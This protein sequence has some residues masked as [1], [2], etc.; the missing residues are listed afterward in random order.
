MQRRATTRAT[1]GELTA[2]P[3]RV[4]PPHRTHRREDLGITSRRC[5]RCGGAAHRARIDALIDRLTAEATVDR[6]NPA[7]GPWSNA[8]SSYFGRSKTLRALILG[9]MV[10]SEKSVHF[11]GSCAEAF[12]PHH[13]AEPQGL[14][15]IRRRPSRRW[16]ERVVHGGDLAR[17]GAATG[18][19][20]AADH[21]VAIRRSGPASFSVVASVDPILRTHPVYASAPR[22][23]VTSGRRS[24][25]I[26]LPAVRHFT[27]S[28]A[29]IH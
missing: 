17:R 18:G 26:S 8:A 6:E 29:A 20:Q 16:L 5:K 4:A 14:Q 13:A 10:L 2:E 22:A 28:Q 23:K 9:D 15:G 11:P 27:W 1:A 3:P 24:R 12:H 21:Q 7:I 19:R 25:K